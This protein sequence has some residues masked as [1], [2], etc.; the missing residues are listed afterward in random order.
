MSSY[1]FFGLQDLG[2]FVLGDEVGEAM[3]AQRVL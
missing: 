3:R 1:N 2:A